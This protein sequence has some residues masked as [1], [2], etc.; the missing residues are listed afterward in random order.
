MKLIIT[1]TVVLLMKISPGQVLFNN[2]YI[3]TNLDFADAVIERYDGKYLIAGSS[4]SQSVNDYDVNIMLVD[5]DGNLIWDR[6]IGQSP[7]MEFAYSLIETKDSNYLIVG[8][9]NSNPYL[10]KFDSAGS[11]IWDKEYLS[12]YWTDGFS[13]GESYDGNY[14]FVRS[15]TSTTL[16]VTNMAIFFQR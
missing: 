2:T 1:L 10:L 9:V 13:V 15:D 16:F 7:R 4:R 11:L 3:K 8:K 12:A 6:Y 5:S 14:Y